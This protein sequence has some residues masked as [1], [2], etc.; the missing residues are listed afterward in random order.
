M[1]F[2]DENSGGFIFQKNR[3]STFQTLSTSAMGASVDLFI[4]SF[5]S[6]I[7]QTRLANPS[8]VAHR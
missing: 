1:T 2:R 6:Q 8:M 5:S 4:G 7:R 3:F